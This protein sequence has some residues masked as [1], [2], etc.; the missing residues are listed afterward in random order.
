MVGLSVRRRFQREAIDPGR[1]AQAAPALADGLFQ[2]ILAWKAGMVARFA[3]DS[4][5]SLRPLHI[6]VHTTSFNPIQSSV[7]RRLV[8]F[9]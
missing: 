5:L 3:G 7:P 6:T 2:F 8:L 1:E 4:Q 9:L